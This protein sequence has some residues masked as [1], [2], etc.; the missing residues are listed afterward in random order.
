MA[1]ILTLA[2][3]GKTTCLLSYN[4]QLDSLARTFMPFAEVSINK[5]RYGIS[6][7]GEWTPQLSEWLATSWEFELCA[8]IVAGVEPGKSGGVPVDEIFN[9]ANH[10]DGRLL[11]EL[12]VPLIF[13]TAD[14][15]FLDWVKIAEPL[16]DI[17]SRIVDLAHHY[18]IEVVMTSPTD[19]SL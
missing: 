16:D 19:C 6:V 2:C 3:T 8:A 7:V 14:G 9:R 17:G 13:R 10:I 1:D 18:G 4:P 11:L 15:Q 5:Q 12:G